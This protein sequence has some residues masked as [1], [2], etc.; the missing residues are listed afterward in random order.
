MNTFRK[1]LLAFAFALAALPL[2]GC[3]LFGTDGGSDG[4]GDGD[5]DDQ[6]A[7]VTPAP[8]VHVA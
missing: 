1:K 2:G 5:G 8:P 3:D 6:A 7:L 4:G